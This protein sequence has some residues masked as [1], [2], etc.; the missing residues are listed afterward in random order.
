MPCRGYTGYI[1]RKHN[2]RAVF[3]ENRQAMANPVPAVEKTLP[4]SAA[5]SAQGKSLN[6]FIADALAKQVQA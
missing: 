1:L 2:R 5:A 3:S 6:A 4:A